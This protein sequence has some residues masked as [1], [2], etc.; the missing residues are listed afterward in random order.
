MSGRRTTRLAFAAMAV[1]ALLTAC[2]G[3]GAT[4]ADS[5]GPPQPGGTLT[6]L[7][8]ENLGNWD[9][10]LD[11]ATVGLAMR[12]AM[13]AIYG[14]LFHYDSN[15]Q[16][17]PDLATGYETSEDGKTWTIKLRDGVIFSDGTPFNSEA[18]AWNIK[19]DIAATCAC[20]PT[21]GWPALSPEG[22]TTPDGQTV[23]L[24][25]TTP[26]AAVIPVLI[27]SSA[28]YVASP[29][30]VAQQGED[31]FKL[32]PVGAGPFELVENV[33]NSK[34]V[35]KRNDRYWQQGHPYLDG[36]ILQT[37]GSDQPAYQALLAGQA[38]GT[39]LSSPALVQKAI[40]DRKLTITK[41]AANTVLGI[42][43][44]T[45]T[46]PFNDIRAREAISY[47]TD[48]QA[49]V[50]HV[51]GGQ[52]TVT[53]SFTGPG[54]PYFMP[55]V[56]GYRSYDPAK[57]KQ[58]VSE[59][60][61]LRINLSSISDANASLAQK[62]LISQWS[63]AG[64]ETTIN[65]Y[66]LTQLIKSFE[67]PWQAFYSLAG[68]LEP[69]IS[70]DLP[71]RFSPSSA[72]SGVND[73]ELTRMIQEAATTLD[74]EKRAAKYADI[75]KYVSDH[76]YVTWMWASSNAYAAVKGLNGPGFTSPS[77]QWPRWAEVWLAPQARR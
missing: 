72:Y 17:V 28:N 15:G 56:P 48:P 77:G 76:A 71:Y 40:Q 30:A 54:S 3:G 66:D 43:F 63:E 21:R 55:T 57:A 12:E 58:L 64:I 34:L 16:I 19:R 29:T 31:K 5:A 36:L 10:G 18:V 35:F 22:I 53:Q 75:A 6:Y 52:F 27:T 4:D 13:Q 50:D 46:A 73:P 1:S 68:T 7:M 49:I 44:N 2:G 41:G 65:S 9:R 39:L 23:V 25:F 32:S 60:G 38:Q 62:A 11:S 51:F 47:A 69:V 70:T 20:N 59:L 74:K 33:V 67:G 42:T 14:E 45:K 61:G 24:N 26:S 8:D 37:I